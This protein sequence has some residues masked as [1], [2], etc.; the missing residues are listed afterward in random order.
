MYIH[1]HIYIDIQNPTHSTDLQ[2]SGLIYGFRIKLVKK[3][4]VFVKA[5]QKD[6]VPIVAEGCYNSPAWYNLF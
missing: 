6:D 4:C 3:S 1:T 5:S 2:C